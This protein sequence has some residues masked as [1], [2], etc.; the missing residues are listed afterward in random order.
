MIPTLRK[1]ARR[2]GLADRR[3]PVC[4][5]VVH[6]PDAA[7][8]PGCARDLAPRTGGYC[9]GCGRMSGREQDPPTLCP[10]CRRKPPPWSRLHFHGR[11]DGPL[12]D[13]ILSYKF[14]GFFGHAR[15]LADL[16]DRAFGKNGGPVPDVIVPVPLHRLRLVRRGFNQS[17]ELSRMLAKTL[18]RPVLKNGLSRIRYTVPQT[19]LDR[20]E[21]RANIKNAF[22]AD[23]AQVRD[24]RVLLVDDVYTTGSTL[25]ECARTLQRAGADEVEALVLARAQR[26]QD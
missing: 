14:N 3:C 8:C 26:K 9:P 25:R 24:K 22:A 6:D 4:G 23:P 1:L 13:L 17:A 15:L 20:H 11:Y 2:L 5:A 19:R 16:A 18:H 12:R 21:R 10:K 7:F